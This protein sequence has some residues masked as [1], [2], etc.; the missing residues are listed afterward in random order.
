LQPV[1]IW[2]NFA[3]TWHCFTRIFILAK[4]RKIVVFAIKGELLYRHEL[5]FVVLG[6][7]A[8]KAF[9]R[10]CRSFLETVNK[11]DVAVESLD[12]VGNVIALKGNHALHDS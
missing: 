8:R 2:N 7:G 4:S 3:W 6:I 12:N 5:D 10:Y 11:A 9:K 1:R